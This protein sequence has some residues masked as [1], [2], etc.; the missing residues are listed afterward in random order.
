MNIERYGISPEELDDATLTQ[1]VE[2][3]REFYKDTVDYDYDG[4]KYVECFSP[5]YV[6]REMMV[7][8]RLSKAEEYLCDWLV[9]LVVDDIREENCLGW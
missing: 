1:M 4:E 8:F 6:V 9:E 2:Y 5:D 7:H 3:I